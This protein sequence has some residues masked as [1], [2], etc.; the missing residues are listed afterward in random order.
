MDAPTTYIVNTLAQH[1]GFDSKEAL[2]RVAEALTSKTETETK[3]VEP[4][5]APAPA[6]EIKKPVMEKKKTAEEKK[7]EREAKK[8]AEKAEREAKINVKVESPV[9]VEMESQS[10][11]L[12]K[13]LTK[14][15]E[16]GR[17]LN[18][19]SSSSE[20]TLSEALCEIKPYIEEKCMSIGAT[21]EHKKSISLFECQEYL[22]KRGGPT[23]NEEKKKVSMKPDGG[24]FIMKLNGNTIPLLIIEDKVQGTNDRLYE[25]NKKRQATGNAIERAGKNIRGAEMLFCSQNIFPYV[26]F[27]S[28]CDF[29]S[30]ET[31]AQRIEMMNGGF[32]NHYIGVTPTT[33]QNE[34]ITKIKNTILPKINI[35]KQCE[36]SMSIASVFV[37]A[38]KSDEMKHG[39]SRWKKEEIVLICK[40]VIDKVFASIKSS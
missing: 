40:N 27:A 39:S 16:D 34:I 13:R 5:P 12:S 2:H 35:E 32:P 1:F 38:H 26:I 20:R 30:S 22:E 8:A 31:I 7:A 37:K 15:V 11:G 24:I 21:L 9:K 29:H 3:I 19:D 17:R 33:S 4:A 25:Q 10:N 28:G 18:D 6:Q 14:M 23:P 36:C